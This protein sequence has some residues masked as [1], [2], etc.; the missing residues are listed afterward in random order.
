MIHNQNSHTQYH[1][2]ARR[3]SETHT[4]RSRTAYIFS[5]RQWLVYRQGQHRIPTT[6][7]K[8][9]NQMWWTIYDT[10]YVPDFR[11]AQMWSI[12]KGRLTCAHQL[13]HQ[14]STSYQDSSFHDDLPRRF[15]SSSG[16]GSNISYFQKYGYTPLSSKR[17]SSVSL[18]VRRIG[19]RSQRQITEHKNSYIFRR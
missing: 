7:R 16:K 8:L 3:R 11:S 9:Y 10:T 17:L 18:R 13:H 1:R 14:Q 6:K 2:H 4:Q 19:V 5:N 12:M 15:F